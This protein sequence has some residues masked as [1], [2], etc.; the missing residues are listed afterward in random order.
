MTTVSNRIGVGFGRGLDPAETVECVRLADEL[1]YES[2][3]MGEGHAGDQ[4]AI[5]AACAGSTRRIKL[6]TG[7][8]S[9][10]VRTLPTIAMAAATV[11]QLSGGR[12]ILG[13]GISHREQVEPEHGVASLHMMELSSRSHGTRA[14]P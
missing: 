9:V 4:F 3:W 6:G 7:I 2:A 14:M 8:S 12:F 1:G 11:D 5:L 10:F 13:L